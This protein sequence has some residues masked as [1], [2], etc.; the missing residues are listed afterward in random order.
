[1]VFHV[2]GALAEIRPE[3]VIPTSNAARNVPYLVSCNLHSSQLNMPR[4]FER[5]HALKDINVA[6]E[7]AAYSLVLSPLMR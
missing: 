7:S 6:I 5:L 3:L 4:I 1:M 2:H